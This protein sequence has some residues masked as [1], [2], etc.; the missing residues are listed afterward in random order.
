MEN[1]VEKL[2]TKLNEQKEVIAKMIDEKTNAVKS[3]SNEEQAKIVEE[4]KDLKD[5]LTDIKNLLD[6]KGKSSAVSV[7]GLEDE[8]KQF[9]LAKAANMIAYGHSTGQWDTAVKVAGAGFENEVFKAAREKAHSIS[10]ATQGG[11]LVPTEVSQQIVEILLAKTVVKEAGATVLT[12]LKG[13]PFE[14]VNQDT[15]VVAYIVGEN[16]SITESS[17]TF[18]QL[19]MS[20]KSFAALVKLSRK[21]ATM[22]SPSLEMF[23]R[24]R[25]AKKIALRMDLACLRGTGVSP[26]PLG[27]V[28]SSGINTVSIGAN[29]GNFLFDTAQDMVTELENDNV[30]INNGAFISHPKVFNKMKKE[31]IA[32]YSTDTSGAYVILPMTD[33]NLRDSLGYPFYKSTQIPTNLTKG[34][35]TSLSEVIFGD[36]SNIWIGMWGGIELMPSEHTSDAFAKNQIWVRAIQEADCL[37]TRPEAFTL[38]NDAATT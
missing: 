22:T 25:M 19:T 38:V 14:V 5:Q 36:F 18:G 28:N 8:K 3:A 6:R 37:V 17:A 29:G 26:D 7:P 35:G 33:Q 30:D 2:L 24:D 20:P 9:S 21:S 10:D 32:Q 16:K 4:V 34:T 23:L 15:D 11:F 27:I 31:R 1:V 12:D 13:S